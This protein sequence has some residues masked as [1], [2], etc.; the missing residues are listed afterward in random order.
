MNRRAPRAV[1][2][3]GRQPLQ[4]R[5]TRAMTVVE[6]LLESDPSIRWQVMRE[7]T[8]QLLHR[9]ARARNADFGSGRRAPF[10]VMQPL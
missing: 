10:R 2:A 9:C 5:E 1:G 8:S 3:K 4:A 7:L 6:W